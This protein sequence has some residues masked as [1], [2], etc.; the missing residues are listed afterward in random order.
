M[1]DPD[2]RMIALDKDLTD[3]AAEGICYFRLTPEQRE[4]LMACHEKYSVA[5]FEFRPGEFNFGIILQKEGPHSGI[6]LPS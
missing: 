2:G 6:I 5:G 4:T 3:V 1:A